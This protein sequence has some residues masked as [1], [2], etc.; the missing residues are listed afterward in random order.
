R[1]RARNYG[2]QRLLIGVTAGGT[3]DRLVLGQDDATPYGMLI[4]ELRALE[5]YTHA[6]Q[7]GPRV[8]IQPAADELVMA[9][10]SHGLARGVHWIPHI[11][12]A[13]SRPDGASYQDPLEFAPIGTT[14][15]SLIALC[16]A[17]LDDDKPDFTLFVR[18]PSTGEALDTQLLT[19]LKSQ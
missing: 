2:I 18:V 6:M 8:S 3:I 15:Q 12:V 16:G 11:G 5:A 13:Y 1:A 4:P 10:G 17:V 7:T 14:I 9:P 19:T